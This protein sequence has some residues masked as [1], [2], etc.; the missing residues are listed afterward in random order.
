M[1]W[2]T[3]ARAVRNS[4]A[5]VIRIFRNL[6]E[7]SGKTA[8]EWHNG[9]L[10]DAR[11]SRARRCRG[12]HPRR[13]HRAAAHSCKEI[14]LGG[15]NA[16]ARHCER[17][18]AIQNPSAERFLDCFAALAMTVLRERASTFDAC[19][20]RSAAS[21]RRC[22]AEPGP[23]LRRCAC[24]SGSRLCTATLKGVAVRPG[25]G[26]T[27]RSANDGVTATTPDRRDRPRGSPSGTGTSDRHLRRR[28]TARR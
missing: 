11:T 27:P 1:P 28:R 16:D 17:S 5:P 10:R 6:L 26:R 7:A 14:E 19:P 22:A 2:T 8:I 24:G 18:E 3:D 9:K 20:G 12:H 13:R 23:R 21:L 25:H 15:S 4:A